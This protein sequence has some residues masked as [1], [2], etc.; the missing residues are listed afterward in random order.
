MGM[1]AKGVSII[2]G[3]DGPTSIFIAGRDD[4]MKTKRRIRNYFRLRKRDRVKKKITANPHTWEEVI[5]FI[6]QGYG[7]VEVSKQSRIYL[8]QRRSIKESRIMRYRPEL[9]GTLSEIKPPK[10]NDAE[11][12]QE[13]FEQIELRSKRAGAVADEVFPIDFHLYEIKF[14]DGGNMQIAMEKVWNEL[15][16]SYS[17]DKKRMKQL[18][19]LCKRIYLYFGVTAEDI[20]NQTERYNTLLSILCS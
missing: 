17:G 20:E 11:A 19:K 12:L 2:G 10:R 4:K 16:V 8:E 1:H 13:F 3:A 7:A 5:R 9:L 18:K 14:P 15:G 6:E